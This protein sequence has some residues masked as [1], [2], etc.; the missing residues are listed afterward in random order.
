VEWWTEFKK[1]TRGRGADARGGDLEGGEGK[2]FGVWVEVC[3][4]RGMNTRE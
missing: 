4:G 2:G 3:G 1:G